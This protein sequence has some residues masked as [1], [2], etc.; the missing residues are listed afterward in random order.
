MTYLENRDGTHDSVVFLEQV[1]L[2]VGIRGVVGS[3]LELL[4]LGCSAN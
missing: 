4:S 2:D 1:T 3:E